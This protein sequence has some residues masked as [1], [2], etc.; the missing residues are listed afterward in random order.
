MIPLTAMAY[1]DGVWPLIHGGWIFL[2]LVL[3]N[4]QFCLGRG[5][6]QLAIHVLNF[7]F[8][9]YIW[10][11]CLFA[12]GLGGLASVLLFLLPIPAMLY[13][14]RKTGVPFLGMAAFLFLFLY[15]RP[16]AGDGVLNLDQFR[17]LYLALL[18]LISAR[19]IYLIKGLQVL[20]VVDETDQ[21]VET[22]VDELSQMVVQ[23]RQ[24][25]RAKTNFLANM[26]HEIRNPMNGIIGMMHMLLET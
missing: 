13:P 26:S 19:G 10:G 23:S 11:V 2:A 22:H 7:L 15:Q 25:A 1:I 20:Y 21:V 18:F 5:K 6:K 17:Y 24:D 14:D 9:L 8:I 16:H 12:G 4:N 3:V